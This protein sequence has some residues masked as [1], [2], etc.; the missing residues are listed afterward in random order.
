MNVTEFFTCK[1]DR[2]PV[3]SEITIHTIKYTHSKDVF[4]IGT[5]IYI[6]FYHSF[7]NFVR[8]LE[9]KKKLNMQ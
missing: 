7:Y 9:I 6:H 5:V 4:L 2:R 8:K 3:F 1:E